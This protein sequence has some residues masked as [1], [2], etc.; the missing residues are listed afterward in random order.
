M[1][2]LETEAIIIIE[3]PQGDTSKIIR[4]ITRD[5]GKVSLIAKGAR[6]FKS[7]FGGALEPLNVVNLV[8]YYKESRNLQ[9]L[10]KCDII[11]H[12]ESIRSDLQKLAVGLSIA[13]ILINLIME[14]EPNE[15]L[16]NLVKLSLDSLEGTKKR[17]EMAY[18]YFLT[19]FLHI[20][21]F[22]MNVHNC[23][24]CGKIR[25]LLDIHFSISSGGILC[26]KCASKESV[27]RLSRET[28]QVLRQVLSQ[29]LETLFNIK[30][31][32]KTVKELTALF[33]AFYQYHFDGYKTPQALQL[34]NSVIVR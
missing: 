12:Y 20:S 19:R 30:A 21:G 2:L 13:E 32:Q 34:L 16:F 33:D 17:Y 27:R 18:W 3:M 6:T 5:Y 7:R 15:P 22:G 14:E 9:L 24:K 4:V 29:K 26:N 23:Q 28:M 10:S 8:Y 31:S 11:Q 25:E 1:A